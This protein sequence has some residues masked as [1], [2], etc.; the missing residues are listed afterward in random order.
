VGGLITSTIPKTI[1]FNALTKRIS[2]AYCLLALVADHYPKQD[3]GLVYALDS[4]QLAWK[5]RDLEETLQHDV[6]GLWALHE[7]MES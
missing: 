1:T 3:Q 6:E 5:P 2:L 4:S 7:P